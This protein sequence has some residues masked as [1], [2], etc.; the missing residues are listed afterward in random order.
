MNVPPVI[1][2]R[3]QVSELIG[4]GSMGEV[5]RGLDTQTDEPVAIK[6]LRPEIVV[7]DPELVRR[8]AREG[9]ALR[10]LNHP[11][12]VKVLTTIEEGSRHYIIME[13]VG[14]G[15]LR[16]LLRKQP[17]LPVP[18]VLEIALDLAD[19]LTRAHRLRIIHRD[20][21][22]SN[23]LLAEDG[24][25]RLTDFGA[26]HME[27]APRMTQTGTV[28]GTYAYLSPEACNGEELDARTDIWSFGAVLYEM[29]AGHRPFDEAQPTAILLS[30]LTKPVQPLKQIRP[31][32][33]DAMIALIE[34]M[35]EKDRDRRIP[36][37]RRVGAELEAIMSELHAPLLHV[38]VP[39]RSPGRVS[40]NIV[41]EPETS[42][43]ATP[44]PSTAS[45]RPHNLPPQTTSFVG[46]EEELSEIAER[47]YDPAC[48][49]LTLVGPGGIGKTRL[50][51]Q[52]A[53]EKFDAYSDGACFVPLAEL[54]G[55]GFLSATLANSLRLSLS[56]TVDAKAQV[57]GY[58][59][60]RQMLLILDGFEHLI[61]E[62]GLVAEILDTAPAVKAL[63]TSRERLNLRGEWALEVQGMTF[64]ESERVD[65][66]ESYS[67]VELFL[68]NARRVQAGFLLTD[69]DK[70]F[71]IRICRLMEGMPLAIELAS[72]WVKM[73][74]CR[75]ICQEIEQNRDF[76]ESSMR[77]VPERH[78]SLRA[79]FEYSWN[80][81]SETERKAY[82]K[83]SVFH[84]GFGRE[85]AQQVAGASLA[86][87][88]TLVDKSLLRRI[89]SGRYALPGVVRQYAEEKLDENP[90]EKEDAQDRHCAY[91]ANFMQQ[92]EHDLEGDRQ[93]AALEKIGD[94][95]ENVREGWN[96]AVAR[97]KDAEVGRYLESL[98][99][100]YEIRSWVQEGHEA[101]AKAIAQLERKGDNRESR[102]TL[103]KLLARQAVFCHRLARY[104]EAKD[105][106]QKS[107]TIFRDLNLQEESAASLTHLGNISE[108]LGE[109]AEARRLHQESLD[110]F[111]AID[112]REGMALALNNLGDVAR[113]QGEYPNARRLYQ[114]SLAI[115]QEIGDRRS[116]A[117]ALNNL[118]DTAHLVGEYAE[119]AQLY[120]DSLAVCKEIGD[121]RGI[122]RAFNNLGMIAYRQGQYAEAQERCQEALTIFK[123][124][125]DQNGIA[126][127]LTNLGK[128]ALALNDQLQSSQ[129]LRAA[130]QISM[131]LQ[132]I[133]LALDILTT[134]AALLI[135]DEQDAAANRTRAVELLALVMDHPAGEK[136]TRDRAEGLLAE[137]DSELPPEAIMEARERGIARELEELVREIMSGERSAS[138][139]MT[140]FV[141]LP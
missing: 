106:L 13:Y 1:A 84:G 141:P 137:M 94:E 93:K 95:I 88:S 107:L 26:A 40:V 109:Y 80:L 100:F 41:A 23:V 72:S 116:A 43:F 6:F 38:Q 132:A 76:L 134:L 123:A 86:L 114:D 52:A 18:R 77:N 24:T 68:H 51:I 25:P 35:L 59:R 85:A 99:R 140:V 87:L 130:L 36:S 83:L 19:A 61:E 105:L 78:R 63:V 82:R 124:I 113:V 8:F 47:L 71:V 11:N 32:A 90:Q 10:K 92:W 4:Q 91:F 67:A 138:N 96:H 74:S 118:G 117:S 112:D 16:E 12:I 65:S 135:K 79:V 53:V 33:P 133:P 70:P 121:Q 30:I 49:L 115:C 128:L 20:I 54:S 28:I 15:T 29:L 60:E 37:A 122:A 22:P 103:G 46:R 9:E 56:D 111:K 102:A 75:E 57:L 17:Q 64:P 66:I 14:G 69:E 42:R 73:L 126:Y 125:G 81:L 45:A 127:A 21:K 120:Q 50:A 55:A 7:S 58:L 131:R 101:L 136:H 119:A 39:M 108:R 48:R 5:Y 98:Y 44:T 129:H 104:S 3:F 2:D 139:R 89:P 62:A 31:D 97:G 110:A 27:D 34:Q